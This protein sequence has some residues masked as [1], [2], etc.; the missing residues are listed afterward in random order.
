[1]KEL[2]ETLKREI[3]W[4]ETQKPEGMPTVQFRKGFIAG[5]RQAIRMARKCEVS[6]E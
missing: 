2:I 4:C 1:M 5:L 6:H 3:K